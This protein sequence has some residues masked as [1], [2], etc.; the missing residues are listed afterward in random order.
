MTY[1]PSS[2]C[3]HLHFRFI[4]RQFTMKFFI[5]TLLTLIVTAFALTTETELIV[6]SGDTGLTG[7][8]LDSH[9]EATGT[10][11]VFLSEQGD[12]Q[13]FW[14]STDNSTFHTA[15]SD[16]GTYY[17][18]IKD[19]Y[20]VMTTKAYSEFTVVPY[21]AYNGLTSY[22]YACSGLSDPNDYTDLQYLVMY[23]DS[24]EIVPAG[25]K[26]IYINVIAI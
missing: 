10:S 3:L 9:K 15:Y 24:G 1:C 14:R 11:W 16:A 6:V 21:L 26:T 13:K 5:P 22:F 25:C 19:N 12:V 8:Y 7:L 2:L 17:L 20:L 4:L 18:H 23:Y